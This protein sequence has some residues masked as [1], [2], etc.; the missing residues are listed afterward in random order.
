MP[1]PRVGGEPGPQRARYVPDGTVIC[2]VSRFHTVAGIPVRTW[3]AAAQAATI[4]SL[5]SWGWT[6]G[7][8]SSDLVLSG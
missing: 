1:S 3:A 2:G 4:R 6:S 7:G 5:P 8:H